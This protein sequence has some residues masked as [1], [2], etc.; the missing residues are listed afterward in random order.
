[1]VAA[2]PA[3][4]E[5]SSRRRQES[6]S[7]RRTPGRRPFFFFFFFFFWEK[8]DGERYN[9]SLRL[10]RVFTG[11][12]HTAPRKKW[13]F[14]GGEGSHHLRIQEGGLWHPRLEDLRSAHGGGTCKN[15]ALVCRRLSAENQR[16]QK[17]QKCLKGV[18]S[19]G[20]QGCVSGP[21]TQGWQIGQ[22]LLWHQGCPWYALDPQ[23]G[24]QGK[25]LQKIHQPQSVQP[26]TPKKQ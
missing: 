10:G 6:R 22:A 4:G 24:R 18:A 9:P 19:S 12:A 23:F 7:G 25:G 1:M 11:T 2:G 5:R 21:D 17:K 8:H 16:K 15:P 3:W 26:K 20:Y 14:G 13:P